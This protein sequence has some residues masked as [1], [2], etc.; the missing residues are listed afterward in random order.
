MMCFDELNNILVNLDRC[1]FI[2]TEAYQSSLSCLGCFVSF[3]RKITFLSPHSIC[4]FCLEKK[5]HFIWVTFDPFSSS[6]KSSLKNYGNEA[7][8][9][10]RSQI[11]YSHGTGKRTFVVGA[12][13]TLRDTG[14]I[15]TLHYNEM[16]IISLTHCEYFDVS[17]PHLISNFMYKKTEGNSLFK[18]SHFIK[19]HLF[20]RHH[21]RTSA[22]SG[23]NI[24]PLPA[25]YPKCLTSWRS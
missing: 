10:G 13:K 4:Y 16:S 14:S 8:V 21:P 6:G 5:K 20:C 2:L 11:V 9:F 19:S 3:K 22:N 7:I 23:T 12:R 1:W 18:V 24:F 15:Q 17:N 25:T